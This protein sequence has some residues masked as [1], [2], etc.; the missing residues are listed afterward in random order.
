MTGHTPGPWNVCEPTSW[1]ADYDLPAKRLQATY[2]VGVR[3]GGVVALVDGYTDAE[4]AANARL[5]A[6]A[7]DLLDALEAVT[8][9]VAEA[10][11]IAHDGSIDGAHHKQR[12]IDQMV[13]A[14]TGCPWV[15]TTTDS[16]PL[17]L[18]ARGA[19]SFLPSS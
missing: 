12:T 6:S 2:S 16:E 7:P 14:L 3:P 18:V 9:R 4:T 5:I 19:L 11:R 15:K 8:A 10:L 13:R 17:V 1:P